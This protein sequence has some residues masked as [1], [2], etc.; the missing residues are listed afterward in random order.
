MYLTQSLRRAVQQTPHATASIYNGRKRSFAQ[1][2]DR[3]ARFAGALQALGSELEEP[4]GSQAND[5]P[6]DALCWTIETSLLE[7]MGEHDWPPEP[8]PHDYVLT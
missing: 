2:G 7:A 1:L 3:V 8:Q 6:L 4:L 5:L